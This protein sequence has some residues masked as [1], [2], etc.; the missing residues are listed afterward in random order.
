MGKEGVSAWGRLKGNHPVGVVYDPTLIRR[1]RL[2]V[3]PFGDL[4]P[5]VDLPGGK[6]GC[7]SCHSIYN[8]T[9]NL[10]VIPNQGSRLCLTCHIK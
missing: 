7:T 4:P 2:V 5:Q 8:H 3:R 1:G 10:L 9:D 6:V